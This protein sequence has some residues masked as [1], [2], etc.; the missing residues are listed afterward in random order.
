MHTKQYLQNIEFCKKSS[1]Y[2]NKKFKG[3]E[4]TQEKFHPIKGGKEY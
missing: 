4:G 2:L 1:K 3:K